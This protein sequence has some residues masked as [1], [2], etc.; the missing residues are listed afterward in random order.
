MTVTVKYKYTAAEGT[1]VIN[2]DD[3]VKTLPENEQ[4]EFSDAHRSHAWA[5]ARRTSS[6]ALK[7]E[8]TPEMTYVWD[9]AE[10]ADAGLG[11]NPVWEKYHNRYLEENNI[12]LEITK[13]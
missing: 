1:D 8:F 6:G 9:S 13:E 2:F 7:V 3:W 12:T 5:V 10:S 11:D 4:A